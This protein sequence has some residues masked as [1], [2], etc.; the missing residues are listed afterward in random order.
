V[1][2]LLLMFKMEVSVDEILEALVATSGV[3]ELEDFMAIGEDAMQGDDSLG[4]EADKV[5]L[6]LTVLSPLSSSAMMSS[7]SSEDE[8]DSRTTSLR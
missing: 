5:L 3:G 7:S 2:G 4:I 8:E 6:F 1:V